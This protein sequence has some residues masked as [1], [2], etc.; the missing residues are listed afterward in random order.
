MA[1][2]L[3]EVSTIITALD[4]VNEII[5][6]KDLIMCVVRG[7]PSAYS[8]IKQAVRISPTPVDLATLSSWLKSEE[9]NVDLESKLFLQEDAVMEPAIALTASQNNRGGRG[10]GR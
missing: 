4:T 10:G 1:E 5:P 7:L 2:Y 6:E 3:D 9:I 8:S